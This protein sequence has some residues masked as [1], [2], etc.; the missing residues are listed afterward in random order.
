M[1]RRGSCVRERARKRLLRT[2]CTHVHIVLISHILSTAFSTSSRTHVILGSGGK[3]NKVPSATVSLM[4]FGFVEC[5]HCMNKCTICV[6]RRKITFK[7]QQRCE[8]IER[9]PYV[10]KS[11]TS[12]LQHASMILTALSYTKYAF[13]CFADKRKEAYQ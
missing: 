12:T 6:A 13:M 11:I 10:V 9:D 8:C 2:K 7:E 5:A 3:K 4:N 1:S